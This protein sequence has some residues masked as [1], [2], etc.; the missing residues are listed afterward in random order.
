[1]A[2]EQAYLFAIFTLVGIIIGVLFDIFRIL[3]KTI[4]TIDIV[5]YI[6]DIIF[7]LISGIIIIYTMYKF[8]DGQLRFFM[9]IG[10]VLG[11]TIYML[12][13]S[14]YFIK[15]SLFIID[16]IRKILIVPIIRLIK[17]LR[18]IIF[19]PILIICINFR[20]NILNFVK[21]NKKTGGFFVKKEKYNSI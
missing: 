15:I 20:K 21:K 1:M 5:T 16:M 4:K 13:I 3:R 8:C 11:T 19:R 12:T 7:W 14:Q 2:G 10:N 6:E 18:K 9:I 17:V